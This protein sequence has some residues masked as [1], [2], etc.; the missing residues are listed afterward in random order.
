MHFLFGS[1]GGFAE[2]ELTKG[3]KDGGRCS[4]G[5]WEEFVNVVA[6]VVPG[7]RGC[8]GDQ[9]P[10]HMGGTMRPA[11]AERHKHI[12]VSDTSTTR[13]EDNWRMLVHDVFTL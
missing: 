8:H 6:V 12:Q 4:K 13:H 9:A 10:P 7:G 1:P 11:M 3:V 5:F 2:H